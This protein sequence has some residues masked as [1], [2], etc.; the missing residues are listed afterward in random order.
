[1]NDVESARM[2]CLGGSASHS[3]PAMSVALLP[4]VPSGR[5]RSAQFTVETL[6][7]LR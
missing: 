6:E 2:W 5:I 3:T 7:C 1:M 4:P